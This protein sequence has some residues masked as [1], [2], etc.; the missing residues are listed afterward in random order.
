MSADPRQPRGA[1]P[2][3]RSAPGR[4]RRW[5]QMLEDKARLLLREAAIARALPLDA[6][7]AGAWRTALE[8]VAARAGRPADQLRDDIAR[9]VLEQWMTCLGAE[10]SRRELLDH[11]AATLEE[12]ER[13]LLPGLRPRATPPPNS[14]TYQNEVMDWDLAPGELVLDVGSGGWPFA[15][16]THL[17]D[18]YT[19]ETTHRFDRLETGGRPLVVADLAALPFRDKSWDFVFCSHVLEHLDE[20]GRGIRELQRVGRRGYIELPTRLSDVM[21]NFTKFHDHHRWHG[22]LMGD[23]LVFLEWTPAERGDMGSEH[24]FQCLQSAYHNEF[25]S[26][27]ERN[28]HMFFVRCHWRERINFLVLDR[29]GR[30]IDSS[31]ER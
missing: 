5:R 6:D 4:L 13:F 10:G 1:G 25:Q 2:A 8:R 22:Q 12:G 28:W 11:L 30:V 27:F 31:E 9:S 23:T 17:L 16:A 20:P 21:L 19:G 29:N 18:L 3:D 14:W 7:N 26:F 15:R 24:F